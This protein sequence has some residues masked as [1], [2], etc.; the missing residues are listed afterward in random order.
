[1]SE[2]S[3]SAL[4]NR[5]A[6]VEQHRS[7]AGSVAASYHRRYSSRF[8]LDDLVQIAVLDLIRTAARYQPWRGVPFQAYVRYRIRGAI[9]ESEGKMKDWVRDE[10]RGFVTRD[11]CQVLHQ[12]EE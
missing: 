1:M 6:L 8:D 12:V 2:P 3:A 7:L 11:H 5:N 4:E 9:L 10:L